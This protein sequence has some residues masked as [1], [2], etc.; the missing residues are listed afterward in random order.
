MIF[1]EESGEVFL[2][3]VEIQVH[4]AEFLEEVVCEFHDVLQIVKVLYICELY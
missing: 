2:T 1:L 3:S 4:L